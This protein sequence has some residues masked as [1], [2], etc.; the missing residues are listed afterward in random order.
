MRRRDALQQFGLVATFA[1]TSGCAAIL[2][3]RGG[4]SDD[5]D[6]SRAGNLK[7][8]KIRPTEGNDGKLV[9]VVT[10]RN[11]GDK[12]E[13]A[14]LKVSAT[15]DDGVHE[16]EPTVSVPGKKTK[17]VKV[18][19]PVTYKKYDEANSTSIDIDLQ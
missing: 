18:P 13:S 9:V 12:E 11:E 4:N 2:G 14:D 19:L 8:V 6:R 16:T 7:S 3:G 17:D 10:I 15:I 5:G 1:A